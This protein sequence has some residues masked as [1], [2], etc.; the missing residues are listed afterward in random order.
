MRV[1]HLIE[2]IIFQEDYGRI[3]GIKAKLAGGKG[4]AGR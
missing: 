4:L 3:G 1:N 2:A